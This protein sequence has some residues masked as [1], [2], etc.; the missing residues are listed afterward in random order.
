MK[1]IQFF[2]LLILTVGCSEIQKV[3]SDI[4]NTNK[5]I[6]EAT[7][8]IETSKQKILDNSNAIQKST[9]AIG[10]NTDIIEVST[11]GLSKLQE[12]PE[13]VLLILGL[14]LLVWLGTLI[15]IAVLF[16]RIAKR[17]GAHHDRD[18]KESPP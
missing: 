3:N 12:H 15:F 10:K 4:A 18:R 5:T 8:A 14:V 9:E 16:S 1:S 2:A 6:S 13:T 17:I 7:I 11:A